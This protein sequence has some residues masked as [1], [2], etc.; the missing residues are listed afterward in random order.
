M[1][2]PERLLR[3]GIVAILL[4][5][6]FLVFFGDSGPPWRRFRLSH[7]GVV[8]VF[9]GGVSCVVAAERFALRRRIEARRNRS[10]GETPPDLDR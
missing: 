4:G 2:S 6:A 5:I 7:P 10:A 3:T 9:L 1:M 8:M